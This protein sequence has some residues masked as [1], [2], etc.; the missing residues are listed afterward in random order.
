MLI[1][2]APGTEAAVLARCATAVRRGGLVV[3][4]FTVRPGDYGPTAL[5]ADA[6]A[7][8]LELVDRWSTWERDP[9]SPGGDYQ[10]SVHR[11]LS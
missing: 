8:G 1:F 9:W 6:A 2:V 11:R 4:G 3:A 10:V 7:T 5:D